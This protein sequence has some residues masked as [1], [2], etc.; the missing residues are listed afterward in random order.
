MLD[1]RD[2]G[3]QDVT[4]EETT[5]EQ[6]AQAAA[7]EAAEKKPSDDFTRSFRPLTE[8]D[9]IRGTVVH[10]DREGVLVDVGTKSDGLIPPVELSREGAVAAED[11]VSI[12]DQIDVYVLDAEDQEGNLILSKKRADYE[13]AWGR[14]EETFESGKV[15]NAMVT[16]RVKGGLVV[17]L[18]VR[19][20]VPASHVG[21]G[22]V[23]NLERYVGQSLPLKIIEIDRDRKRVVL[24]HRLAVEEE[25]SRQREALFGSLAEGQIREGVVRRVTDYGA[26]VDIG[27]VDGL[28]HVSEMSWTRI[29][30]PSEVVKVGDKIHV[31]VLK[32][33]EQEGK[34]SL[35]LRQI[36]PDPWTEVEGRYH[37]NDIVKGK[38]TRLV[39]FGAFV[40]LDNGIEGII[41]N[42]ELAY[43]RV[44]KPE[45]VVSV[46]DEVTVKV[47]NVR[48]EERRITLSLRQMQ[49]V[50]EQKQYREFQQR[51]RATDHTTIGDVVGDLGAKIRRQRRE[52]RE[53]ERAIEEEIEEYEDLENLDTEA[54]LP[55]ETA[56]APAEVAEVAEV[57]EAAE[58]PEATEAAEE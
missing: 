37:V 36:L 7:P 53:R 27:G 40:Q 2:E 23:R 11:I 1:D 54:N 49:D 51:G 33:N 52:R 50:E 15:I 13:K 35:G 12:G 22:K 21:S 20:F 6:G 3:Q 43:R 45:E 4:A 41:P 32:V 47:I 8:G 25:R 30:H 29:N 5:A 34:I 57:A 38:V 19:G 16:D 28:L 18:G 17:D 56:E 44:N 46:G 58:A 10:I 55:E 9:I 26:F 42:S 39:P 14:I 48:A 31:V 24:S